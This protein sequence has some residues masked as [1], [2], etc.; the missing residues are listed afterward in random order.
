M[1]CLCGVL[2]SSISHR[3]A[4]SPGPQATK[5]ATLLEKG[6]APVRAK[7]DTIAVALVY[8]PD[9]NPTEEALRELGALLGL[10]ATRPDRDRKVRTGPDVLWRFVAAKS[11]A[12]LE[13]K[14]NKLSTRQYQ[15]KDEI[16]Q[17]HDHV[18]WLKR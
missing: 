13:A 6:G 12:A 10:E 2:S 8:G 5:I 15:K 1:K 3:G 11:G 14:T 16:A 4:I 18:E 9:T 17:F 7:L